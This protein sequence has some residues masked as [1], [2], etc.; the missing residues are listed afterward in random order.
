MSSLSRQRG[1]IEFQ[2]KRVVSIPNRNG[3]RTTQQTF[4][5]PSSYPQNSGGFACMVAPIAHIT[6]QMAHLAKLSFFIGHNTDVNIS[7]PI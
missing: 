1:V 4:V 5:T 6:Q 3:Q 2:L 7:V